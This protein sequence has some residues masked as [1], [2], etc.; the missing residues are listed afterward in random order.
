MGP[1]LVVAIGPSGSGKS[2]WAAENFTKQEIVSTDDLRVEYLG[3]VRRQ[4]GDDRVFNEFDQRI[5]NRLELGMRVVADAMHIRASARRRTA[6]LAQKFGAEVIYAVTNRT[7]PA[8]ITHGGWRNDIVVDGKSLIIRTEETFQ[9]QLPSILGGDGLCRKIIDLRSEKPLYAHPLKRDWDGPHGPEQAPLADLLSRGFQGILVI[10]D[11]HGNH[12]GLVKMIKLARQEKLFMVFLGDIVDYA[13]DT[14]K[15]ADTVARLV[16]DGWAI[17]VM[18]NHEKKIDK[19]VS[20][21]RDKWT[22]EHNALVTEC[23]EPDAVLPAARMLRRNQGFDGK[24][25]GGN[26]VTINQ[27]K[28]MGANN[29]QDR[30][31]WETRFMGL[32]ETMPHMIRMPGYT[33]VHGA[34]GPHMLDSTEFRFTPE[35][36]QESFAMFGQSTGKI[37]NGFPERIYDWV[38]EIPPRM[39]V[40]VGH[41]CRQSTEPLIHEGAAG[42][43]VIFLDTGSSKPDRFENGHLSAMSLQITSRRKMGFILENEA[44]Y[45][46]RDLPA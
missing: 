46:E 16:F 24:I 14:L 25:S 34:I 42:G 31:S 35:S 13:T 28:A 10:S 4:D 39:T 38:D 11:V 3:D 20:Y 21:E 41:D 37:V 43:R 8:K 30:F 7:I 26:L 40:V 15:C 2:H 33:F 32:C 29:P 44:F 17:S 9:G 19:W 22:G 6:K 36:A 18:G 27:I 23:G 45:D 5:C 12:D 1:V